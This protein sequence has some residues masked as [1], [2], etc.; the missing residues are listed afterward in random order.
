MISGIHLD[1]HLGVSVW[2]A[3]VPLEEAEPGVAPGP[4]WK[5][6]WGGREILLAPSQPLVLYCIKPWPL[7][8]GCM[9]SALR[10]FAA[11]IN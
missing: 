5:A 2:V 11:C 7:S 10:H 6:A 3:P 1:K 8:T 9:A 4:W